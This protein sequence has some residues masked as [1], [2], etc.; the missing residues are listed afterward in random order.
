MLVCVGERAVALLL[1]GCTRL[2]MHE[3][4]SASLCSSCLVS[5][6]QYAE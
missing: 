6:E 2:P 1:K 4:L 3:I 5:A